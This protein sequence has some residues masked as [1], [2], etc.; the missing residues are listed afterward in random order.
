M[1]R[2]SLLR[3]LGTHGL[4]G[5]LAGVTL[6]L[7]IVGL[8]LFSL[9]ALVRGGGETAWI[10]LPLLCFFFGLTFGSLQMGL[11]VEAL[12]QRSYLMPPPLKRALRRIGP[13]PGSG[14]PTL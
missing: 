1:R 4:L 3:Y 10:G 13:A 12:S 2:G 11:A 14:G 9:G 7:F 6:A 5:M 8:D